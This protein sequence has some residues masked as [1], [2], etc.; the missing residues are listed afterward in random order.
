ML[1]KTKA[2]AVIGIE[3]YPVE[4]EVNASGKGKENAFYW[5]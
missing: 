1:A 2:A 5:R 4:V 3:A